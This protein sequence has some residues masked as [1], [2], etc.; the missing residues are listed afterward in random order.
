VA[1]DFT[2]VD[3]LAPGAVSRVWVF[4]FPDG[5]SG[6]HTFTGHWDTPDGEDILTVTVDFTTNE[7]PD[8]RIA[9]RARGARWLSPAGGPSG[10]SKKSRRQVP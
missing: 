1:A 10:E 6:I 9:V 3:V 8:G 5:L 4:S 2:D 7:I